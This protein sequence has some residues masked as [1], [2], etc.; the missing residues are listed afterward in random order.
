MAQIMWNHASVME[1]RIIEGDVDWPEF[2]EKE[3]QDLYAFLRTL[4]E[5]VGKIK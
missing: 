4:G 3:M 5:Q 1:E 2:S